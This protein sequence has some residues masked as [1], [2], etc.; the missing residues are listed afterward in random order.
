MLMLFLSMCSACELNK[1]ARQVLCIVFCPLTT[2]LKSDEMQKQLYMSASQ[3]LILPIE[4]KPRPP[5]IF[6]SFCGG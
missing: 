5:F 3:M 6:K 2:C 1:R 4:T